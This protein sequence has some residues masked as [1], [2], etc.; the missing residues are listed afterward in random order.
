MIDDSALRGLMKAIAS[1]DGPAALDLL[2]ASP[3][4][5]TAAL[6]QG[7][8]RA[9]ATDNFLTEI[10]HYVYAGDTAL[11]VA[12]AAHRPEIARALIGLGA[13]VAARNRRG[14]TPLHYAA[15][16]SPGSP[17][18]N[19]AH[20]A[21]TIAMLIASG[22]NPN[23]SDKNDVTPLHRA[24]RTRSAAAVSAL[25]DSGADARRQNGNGST[26]AMLATRQT[27][28]S[29]SGSPEAK[30]Q[31]AEIICLFERHGMIL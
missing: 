10:S 19:P 20:Q 14:A 31:Q 29:G 4:L 12:A 21:E 24:V 16:G 17:R 18:W 30:A 6:K 15:D 1:G 5:A 7:A 26:P 9:A 3:A 13:E 8:T 25:I 22:A 28:R 2:S 11:H 23:A 27:G